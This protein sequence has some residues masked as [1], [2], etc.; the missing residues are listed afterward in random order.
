MVGGF[1][2]MLHLSA[3]RHSDI[4]ETFKISC[5]MGRKTPYERRFGRPSNESVIPFG[6]MVDYHLIS[7]RDLSRRHQFG[8]NALPGIFLRY[9]LCAGGICKGGI[10]VADIEYLEDLD[11]SELH[12]RRLNAKEVSTPRKGEQFIFPVAEGT[13]KIYGEDQDL[14]TSTFIR[15][16][17]DRGEE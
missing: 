5:L 3:K 13:V 17:P 1:H 14:R 4:C 10:M 6:A 2:G 9:V 8:P 16:S 7:D 12:A 11:A 15:E